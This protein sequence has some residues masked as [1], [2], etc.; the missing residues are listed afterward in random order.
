MINL[1]ARQIESRTT[2]AHAEL[3]WPGLAARLAAA[4]AT[5]QILAGESKHR[6]AACGSFAP[7]WARQIDATPTSVSRQLE[8]HAFHCVNQNTKVDRKPPG[9]IEETS[10]GK[11]PTAVRGLL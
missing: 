10:K 1:A 4:H 9:T 7:T 6:V 3:D 8:R 11:D 2:C 5:R